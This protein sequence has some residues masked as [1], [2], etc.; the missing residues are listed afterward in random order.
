MASSRYL[1]AASEDRSLSFSSTLR[2]SCQLAPQPVDD[3]LAEAF[4]P[5]LLGELVPRKILAQLG[6]NFQHR[7]QRLED[8][9]RPHRLEEPSAELVG[10]LGV[11]PPQVAMVLEQLHQARVPQRLLLGRI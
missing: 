7:K 4:V 3:E 2:P 6:S 9:I 1:R 8:V 11:R 10:A 5:V